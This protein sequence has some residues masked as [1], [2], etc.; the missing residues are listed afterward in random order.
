MRSPAHCTS[1]CASVGAGFYPAPT[2]PTKNPLSLRGYTAPV[3][4]RIPRPIRRGRRPRRP[5][6]RTIYRALRRGRWSCCGAQNFCAALRRTLKILAAATRSSRFIRHRRRS[7]RSPHRPARTCTAP[8]VKNRV[9]AKPVR[10]LAVAIRT[11]RPYRLPYL[12]GGNFHPPH[13][14]AKKTHPPHGQVRFLFYPDPLTG[15]S[16][17]RCRQ[18]AFSPSAS[19]PVS[20]G[21]CTAVPAPPPG[22]SR[23]P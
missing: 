16:V 7:I 15:R 23:R 4:I 19:G 9:I 6:P 18:R 12:K 21:P 22:L 14:S 5:A 3:A 2:P 20:C 17:P 1:C 13:L 8:L 11:P 10:T